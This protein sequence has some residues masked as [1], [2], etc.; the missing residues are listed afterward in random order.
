MRELTPQ[1]ADQVIA[2]CQANAGEIAASLGR[3]LGAE[4]IIEVG[5][6][7]TFV[8]NTVPPGS[9]L[10]VLF[11]YGEVGFLAIL[12]D[13]S[14]LIPGWCEHPD[15]TGLSKLST[16]AQELS[17]QLV[18]DSLSTEKFHASRVEDVHL[19]VKR[20]AV[21]DDAAIVNLKLQAGDKQSDLH[22]VWPIAKPSEFF[23]SSKNSEAYAANSN[24]RP[25]PLGLGELPS[26]TRSLLKITLPVRVV[27][28]T[29]K[30]SVQDVV[31]LAPGTI[32]KFSKSCDESLQLFVGD[33]YVALGEAVKVGDKFGFRVTQMTLPDEHFLKLQPKQAG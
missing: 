21:A 20:A 29:K 32:I 5:K 14:G 1:L 13:S 11:T 33:Q 7:G 24:A 30:E 25:Q 23:D 12:S 19:A 26:Y 15:A 22:L 3:T 2:A 10:A 31:E 28:A 18:P 27:L 9:A 17:M 16:L 8:A 4:L 6:S